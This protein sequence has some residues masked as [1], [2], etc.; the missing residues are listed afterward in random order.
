MEY[1][2]PNKWFKQAKVVGKINNEKATLLLDSGAEISILDTTFA[3]KVGC[4][5]DENQKQE[6]VGI[7]ENTYMTEG[8]TKIKITLNGSLVYYFDVWVGD[9][10]G[11]EAILGMDF[12]VPAGVRLD[13]ADGTLVLP[14]EVRIHLAGRRPLY[15]AFMHPI[16][17]PEQHVVLPAG[18]SAEIRIGPIPFT[19]KLWVRRDPKWVPT[20]TTGIGR[21]KYLQLTNLGDKEVI[22]GHGS[23]LG[24][25]T[26]A[27]KIIRYEGYFSV[28]SQKYQEWQTLAFEAT[29]EKQEESPHAYDGP[30]VDHPPYSTPTK[31]L[32]RPKQE[33]VAMN[34][35]IGPEEV[36]T[37]SEPKLPIVDTIA[38]KS[39]EDRVHTEPRE[40]ELTFIEMDDAKCSNDGLPD[41]I[42]TQQ[43]DPR[44]TSA[45]LLVHTIQM[46]TTDDVADDSRSATK[47]SPGL[48]IEEAARPQGNELKIEPDLSIHRHE[49]GELYAE[50]VDQHMTVLPEIVTPTAEI[51]INDIQVGDPD[52]PLTGDQERL[53]ELIWKH[54]HLL[55]GKGNAL[56][57]AARGAI[58]DIDVGG[59]SPIA[60]R[61]RP[62]APK[63]REKLADLIKG[64]LSARII[65]PSTSPWASPIVVIIKKNGEDIRLCIDYRRVNQLTRLM[66]YPMPL[67]NELLQDMD[68]A[69]WYCSLDMASGFWVVEMTER[70]RMVSAFITPSGLFEWLRMPFGLKNAP[71]IYQRLIDNALYGYLKIGADPDAHATNSSKQMNVFIEGEPDTS[72][73]PSVLG[74]RSYIDDILIPATSW[75]AL[76]EK[77]KRLIC[78]CDKWN[79]SISLTKSVWGRRKVDY[80]GHQV[81]LAGLEAHP[82]DLGSLVNIPFP[83]TL[84]SMQSFL[85]S[86]NYYSRFIEDFAIYA[87]VLYELREEDFHEIRRMDKIVMST[88]KDVTGGDPDLS[89]VT[90]GDPETNDQKSQ[91]DSDP[92]RTCVS[93]GD[94][95]STDRSRWRRR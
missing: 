80:L 25:C 79:L 5:I 53:R 86:L 4:V 12:M 28:G 90:G 13:L 66:V 33:N 41:L 37:R 72:Q 40:D 39:E 34:G 42:D 60:Q 61:V 18:G 95:N 68:K 47:P 22:L 16:V 77:V 24:W 7:G 71:Q 15:G 1:H 29:T 8:R 9:Q 14:D 82:K 89:C 78:V 44:S 10:V 93:G 35:P 63:F 46:K 49:S 6:C 36:V 67:I 84:R 3:R 69:M 56:P 23:P 73:T 75:I 21:I 54:K 20:V 51:T 43:V 91:G 17:V 31:I 45:R 92:D 64:L 74:R 62:V 55:I 88:P 58:C 85:G 27:D 26:A 2:T 19:S 94:A 70:A 59:A 76:H 50:D 65:R 52:M 83:R 11:Q 57:P 30:L 87:S 81:S 48:T 38:G 32:S